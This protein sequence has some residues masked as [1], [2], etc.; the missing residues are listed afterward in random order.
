M[1]LPI[2]FLNPDSDVA[3]DALARAMQSIPVGLP[4]L[5][6]VLKVHANSRGEEKLVNFEFADP[7]L[8]QIARPSAVTSRGR[9]QQHTQGV[10]HPC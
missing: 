5:G 3:R 1:P 7:D 9:S 10:N 8:I 6:L 4:V 2:T